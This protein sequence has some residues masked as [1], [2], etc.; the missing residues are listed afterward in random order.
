MKDIDNLPAVRQGQAIQLR[1]IKDDTQLAIHSAGRDYLVTP[2]DIISWVAPGAPLHE[3][4]KFLVICQTTGLNPLLGDI[5][6]FLAGNK[7]QAFV[8]KN[9]YLKCARNDPGYDG[10]ESGVTIQAFQVN[11]KGQKIKTGPFLDIPGTCVPDGHLLIGGWCRMWRK[12]I[13]RPF[14]KRVSFAEYGKTGPGTWQSIPCTMIEKVAIAHAARE[15]ID[16][17]ANTYDESEMY[18]GVVQTEAR[19]KPSPQDQPPAAIGGPVSQEALD[20]INGLG[21]HKTLK[22]CQ[23]G[24]IDSL[25]KAVG[26]SD[27]QYAGM[28]TKRSVN[29]LDELDEEQLESILRTLRVL[30]DQQTWNPFEKSEPEKSGETEVIEAEI[31]EKTS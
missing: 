8:R 30:R 9:G 1:D 23:I 31:V 5:D 6:L 25:V 27:G 7:W 29:N 2:R 11:P 19:V 28:L 22:E 3:A 10:H 20:E 4:K 12:G 17:L 16:L 18:P 24:E 14:F 15:C 21:P 26:M 13:S